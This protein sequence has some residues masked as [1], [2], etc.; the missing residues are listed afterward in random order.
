MEEGTEAER[1]LVVQRGSGQLN[2]AAAAACTRFPGSACPRERRRG[3]GRRRALVGGHCCC[4]APREPLHQLRPNR[5]PPV[6]ASRRG[7][8]LGSGGMPLFSTR[9]SL[10]T[11]C[12]ERRVWA[13]HEDA[14]RGRQARAQLV[15]RSMAKHGS[16]HTQGHPALC[17]QRLGQ[18]AVCKQ[19]RPVGAGSAA[20]GGCMCMWA[21]TAAC[22]AE[23]ALGWTDC[24]AACRPAAR[25][26]HSTPPAPTARRAHR[27]PY[28][29]TSNQRFECLGDTSP[30]AAPVRLG[31]QRHTVCGAG[32]ICLLPQPLLL[33]L[34]FTQH[35]RCLRRRHRAA[36]APASAAAIPGS[37]TAGTVAAPPHACGA[38][39]A[40]LA[41][42]QVLLKRLAEARGDDGDVDLA[43]VLQG[44]KGR[45]GGGGTG[46]VGTTRPCCAAPSPP[47]AAAGSRQTGG[48][49]AVNQASNHPTFKQTHSQQ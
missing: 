1:E 19:G 8:W 47:P 9:M 6:A 29:R 35:R 21:C 26:M 44:R 39:R 3:A 23:W 31:G 48:A 33:L 18:V 20:L 4:A 25:H 15:Q 17:F 30:P 22:A 12:R 49:S 45:G 36:G 10:P 42:P 34:Q 46:S 38:H 16:V 27:L 37:A 24:S 32:A 2:E 43:L 11:P 41:A 13:S 14:A 40:A 5:P 28:Q 7:A